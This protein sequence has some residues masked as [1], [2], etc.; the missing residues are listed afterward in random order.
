[1]RHVYFCWYNFT[2]VINYLS[3]ILTK[4]YDTAETKYLSKIPPHVHSL[5]TFRVPPTFECIPMSELE[6]PNASQWSRFL[7]R[8]NCNIMLDCRRRR[9][10]PE[11]LG[12]RVNNAINRKTRYKKKKKKKTCKSKDDTFV[13]GWPGRQSAMFVCLSAGRS[14]C[15]RAGLK[16]KGSQLGWFGPNKTIKYKVSRRAG[17]W[18]SHVANTQCPRLVCLLLPFYC[19]GACR[20]ISGCLITR[21]HTCTEQNFIKLGI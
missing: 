6:W 7:D 14:V 20:G 18:L 4:F 2:Q 13:T 12:K 21:W 16:V 5:S 15:L 9:N 3:A 1:M 8:P 10:R 11:K 19:R 17:S